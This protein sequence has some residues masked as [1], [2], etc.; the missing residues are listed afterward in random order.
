MHLQD[1]SMIRAKLRAYATQQLHLH[2]RVFE[3]LM[4]KEL[5]HPPYV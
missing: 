1:K 3:L 2:A 4:I 5:K